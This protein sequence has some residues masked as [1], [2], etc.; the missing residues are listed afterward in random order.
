M[1]PKVAVLLL[2]AI[3]VTLVPFSQVDG[4][5][6]FEASYDSISEEDLEELLGA[7]Y[8]ENINRYVLETAGINASGDSCPLGD[9]E[10]SDI[11]FGLEIN[12]DGDSASDSDRKQMETSYSYYLEYDIMLS[13]KANSPGY[14]A[15]NERITG[16]AFRFESYSAGDTG[17][18]SGHVRLTIDVDMRETASWQ[19]EQ[20]V[21]AINSST[22]IRTAYGAIDLEASFHHEMALHKA[23][24]DGRWDTRSVTVSDFIYPD[25]ENGI[26]PGDEVYCRWSSRED[27]ADVSIRFQTDRG[28]FDHFRDVGECTSGTSHGAVPDSFFQ[29]VSEIDEVGGYPDSVSGALKEFARGEL[30]GEYMRDDGL[31]PFEEPERIEEGV[32]QHVMSLLAAAVFIVMAV[33]KM[34]EGLFRY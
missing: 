17:T 16:D 21:Y 32:W 29:N 30:A 6:D 19:A 26:E 14:D 27:S 9:A 2:V 5:S 12:G 34:H 11:R 10:T 1:T 18:V 7:G 31:D 20:N 28:T 23:E 4:A 8:M 24:I 13:F 22:V 3:A 15:F 25:E 33:S